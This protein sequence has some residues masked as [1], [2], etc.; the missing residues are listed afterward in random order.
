[1]R[2]IGD[3]SQPTNGPIAEQFREITCDGPQHERALGRAG[4]GP[5]QKSSQT[6]DHR[7]CTAGTR[8]D[9]SL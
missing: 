7:E 4:G 8:S 3:M 9:G 2:K 1:M 6:T 5:G